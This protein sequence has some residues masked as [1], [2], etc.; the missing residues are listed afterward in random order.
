MTWLLLF[1][2]SENLTE[3]CQKTEQFSGTLNR[4]VTHV[5]IHVHQIVFMYY[6]YISHTHTHKV[7]I[8]VWVLWKYRIMDLIYIKSNQLMSI[9][10]VFLST[11]SQIES[12]VIVTKHGCDELQRQCTQDNVTIQQAVEQV[13]CQPR[14]FARNEIMAVWPINLR[15]NNISYQQNFKKNCVLDGIWWL[16]GPVF[17]YIL[18]LVSIYTRNMCFQLYSVSLINSISSTSISYFGCRLWRKI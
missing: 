12:M 17:V 2:L 13:K 15:I 5:H 1:Q 8:H 18:E 4:F 6:L 14:L 3:S 11:Y 7:S 10:F 9:V 16:S